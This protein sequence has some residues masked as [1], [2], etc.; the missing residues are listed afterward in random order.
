MTHSPSRSGRFFG[1]FF[2]LTFLS[3]GIGSGLTEFATSDINLLAQVA[4]H[5]TQLIIGVVLMAVFHSLFNIALPSLM[6]P[7]LKQHSTSVVY[8]YYGIAIMATTTLV[9]GGVFL[10]MLLPISDFGSQYLDM[11]LIFQQG[12][13]YA[14]QLGMALWGSGGILLC[15]LL[16]LSKAVPVQFPIWGAIGYLVFIAGTLAELFGIQIG[17]LLSMP[18]GLFEISLS[19]WL[20]VKGFNAAKNTD[21]APSLRPSYPALGK[22]GGDDKGA[23]SFPDPE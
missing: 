9:I 14:Y 5:K 6:L 15:W 7:L 8:A 20:I 10:L 3:Y 4:Q 11:G 16:Y 2:I 19:I 13:F 17:V 18:G 12:N 1:I 22:A 21:K 23:L